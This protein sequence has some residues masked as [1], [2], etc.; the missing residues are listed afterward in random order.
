MGLLI[1]LDCGCEHRAEPFSQHPV[2][3]SNR[4][5]SLR[6]SASR[7]SA[8]ITLHPSGAAFHIPDDWVEWHSEFDNNLHLTIP[9][10]E[11]VARGAGEWDTEYASLC[12]AIFPFDCCAAHVGG[13]GWGSQGGSFGD[14][15]VRVYDMHESPE[16]LLP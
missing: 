12:N 13:E 1:L 6:P 7:Q 5:S 3:R 10:L 11:A 4:E 2:W 9:E 8:V 15:Q 16:A 14:L